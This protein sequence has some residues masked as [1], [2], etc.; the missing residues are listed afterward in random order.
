MGKIFWLLFLVL[1]AYN[2]SAFSDIIQKF[3]L[4]PTFSLPIF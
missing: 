1:K 4:Y 3:R 2:K